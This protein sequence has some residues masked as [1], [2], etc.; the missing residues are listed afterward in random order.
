MLFVFLGNLIAGGVLGLRLRCL[1]LVPVALA[2]FLA[3]IGNIL[4]RVYYD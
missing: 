3:W 4:H 1:A 2:L